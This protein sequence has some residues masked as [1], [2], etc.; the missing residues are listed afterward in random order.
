MIHELIGINNHRVVLPGIS[1]EIVI[2]PAVDQFFKD[3]M[4]LN[5][6]DLGNNLNKLV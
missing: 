6:G 2:N 4:F 1:E 3:N 5:Y